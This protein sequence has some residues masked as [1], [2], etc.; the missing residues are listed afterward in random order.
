MCTGRLRIE[1]HLLFI[2]I[3][4]LLET[5]A[6]WR[7]VAPP[8]GLLGTPLPPGGPHVVV[9][10]GIRAAGQPMVSD[11]T[12]GA[13]VVFLHRHGQVDDEGTAQS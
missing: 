5:S 7:P 11:N 13:G 12:S 4:K 2:T 8:C 3:G 1:V 10:G 6:H 9:P